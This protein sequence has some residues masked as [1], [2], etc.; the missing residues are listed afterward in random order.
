MRHAFDYQ[1]HFPFENVNDLLLWMR[2]RWHPTP[3]G[4]CG[5]HLIHRVAVRDC[6]AS[7]AWANF[8][9]RSLWFHFR[10]LRHCVSRASL[11]S[12]RAQSSW[13]HGRFGARLADTR[14]GTEPFSRGGSA[15]DD[16][17]ERWSTPRFQICY[18]TSLIALAT[19]HSL[20][21]QCTP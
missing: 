15:R 10:I 12:H 13:W 21:A 20:L 18:Q 19:G 3:G 11:S 16:I 14:F 6:T 17:R 7:D 8:N 1:P 2:V 4:E 5:E 9:C